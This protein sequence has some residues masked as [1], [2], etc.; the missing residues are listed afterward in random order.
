MIQITNQNF[1]L[2]ASQQN[3]FLPKQKKNLFEKVN[4]GPIYA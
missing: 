1:Q 3:W 4:F 2:F